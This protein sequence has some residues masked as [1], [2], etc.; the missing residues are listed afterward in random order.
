MKTLFN[1]QNSALMETL[2]KLSVGELRKCCQTTLESFS[3]AFELIC[4]DT[5]NYYDCW[6]RE[7]QFRITGSICYGIFTYSKNKKPD[8]TKKCNNTFSIKNFK[9][10]YTEYG[11]KTEIEA[12]AAFVQHTGLAVIEMGLIVS[13]QNPW[14]AYSPDGVIFDNGVETALLEIKCPF[15]GKTEGVE[16][17]IAS[18]FKKY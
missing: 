2:N 7:R 3:G 16:K 4:D 6:S 11:K 18:L 9:T 8:W 10:E 15:I 13:Q 14:L 5:E 17:T 12:H 1:N